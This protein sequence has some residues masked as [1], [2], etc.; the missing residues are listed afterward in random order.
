MWGWNWGTAGKRTV[1]FFKKRHLSRVESFWTVFA[2]HLSSC[3]A[4][5]RS[6][7]THCLCKRLTAG[8]LPSQPLWMSISRLPMWTTTRRSSLLLMLQLLFRCEPQFQLFYMFAACYYMQCATVA[9]GPYYCCLGIAANPGKI[10]W[11]FTIYSAGLSDA[12]FWFDDR[13]FEN[14]FPGKA[15]LK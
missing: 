8:H 10:Y 6:R 1:L 12:W 2:W 5:L 7:A 9:K 13:Y 4:C 11:M 3:L 15:Q 14:H